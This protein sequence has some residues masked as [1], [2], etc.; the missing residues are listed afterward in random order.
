MK[1][2]NLLTLKQGMRLAIA[3][4]LTVTLSCTSGSGQKADTHDPKTVDLQTAVMNNN[5]E[6]IRQHIANKDDLNEKEPFGGST[7]LITAAVFGKTEAADLLIKAGADLNIQNNDG[8]T[9]LHSAAFFCRPDIVNLLL[10]AKADQTIRNKY[11]AT[12]RETVMASF[13]DVRSV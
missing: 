12:A 8:S 5:L 1:T 2:W 10:D 6:A 11:G 9:A 4:L 13:A 7:P 3:A